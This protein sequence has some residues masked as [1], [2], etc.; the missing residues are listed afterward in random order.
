M[1]PLHN[2]KDRVSEYFPPLP[3]DNTNTIKRSTKYMGRDKL[4]QT[5]YSILKQFYSLTERFLHDY[6]YEFKVPTVCTFD[7]LVA[8]ASQGLSAF[9]VFEH[10]IFQLS[11]NF[12]HPTPKDAQNDSY[13]VRETSGYTI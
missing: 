9:S 6:D 11:F 8:K 1:A 4:H 7:N 12:L 3:S 5:T 13:R 10:Q 2:L